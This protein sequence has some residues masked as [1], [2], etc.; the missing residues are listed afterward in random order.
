MDLRPQPQQP[1]RFYDGGVNA[2]PDRAAEPPDPADEPRIILQRVDVDGDEEF[3]LW[4]R[5]AYR[6]EEY[7]ELLVPHDV[8][9]FTSD[10]TSVPALFTWLVPKSG[11]HL[12]AALVHDGLVHPEGEPTYVSTEGHVID[13]VGADRVFRAAMRDSGVGFVRRWLIWS[14]VTLGTIWHGSARWS[15]ARHLRYRAAMVASL[16]TIT[17]LGVLA[18]LDLFDS[19][20]ELWWMGQEK[21]WLEV[22]AGL[23][24]AI[25]VP[26]FLGLLWGRFY[27]AG[28]VNG[29]ALAV[30]LH[31]TVML[32]GVTALYQA[33]E[34]LARRKP[35]ALTVAGGVVVAASVIMVAAMWWW[36]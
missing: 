30:L 10:L 28:V 19:G 18:T 20:V 13:R 24:G 11:Q 25:V 15:P 26:F 34:W 31:V 23:A 32:L 5:I 16:L 6:D 36:V 14:A 1:R 3:R 21:W 22:M 4:R 29:I 2:G 7:G 33:A 35:L 9:D 17:V 8:D 27:V 12:P